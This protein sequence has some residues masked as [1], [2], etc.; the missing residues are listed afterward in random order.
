M[1]KILEPLVKLR[2]N[3]NEERVDRECARGFAWEP[4]VNRH[5]PKRHA[6]RQH[7]RQLWCKHTLTIGTK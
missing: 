6:P 3:A 1:N 4:L 7:C 5:V 2:L